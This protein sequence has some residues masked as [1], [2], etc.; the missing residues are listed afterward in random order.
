MWQSLIM[1]YFARGS[2]GQGYF[3]GC[4]LV[5]FEGLKF[6]L[7]L[8][9]IYCCLVFCFIFFLRRQYFFPQA[10]WQNY[11]IFSLCKLFSAAG[12]HPLIAILDWST[13]IRCLQ[14]PT[15]QSWL[16][17]QALIFLLLHVVSLESNFPCSIFSLSP[18][19]VVFSQLNWA[20]VHPW[21]GLA[22]GSCL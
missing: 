16:K 4:C 12:T 10:F 7:S 20:K 9:C 15:F 18:T 11:F 19:G 22:R 3:P 13:Q 21:T 8:F 2:L 5:S 6:F 14:I 17:F 1:F